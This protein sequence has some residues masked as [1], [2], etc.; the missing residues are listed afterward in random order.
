M[1]KIFSLVFLVLVIGSVLIGAPLKY[2]PQT[3]I[4]PDGSIVK[5]F[6]SGDEYYH[7][8][9]DKDG[10]TITF[11]PATRYWVYAERKGLELLPTNYIVG[12]DNPKNIGIQKWLM[13]DYSILKSRYESRLT[14]LNQMR[15]FKT[16]GNILSK[17]TINN[18]VVFVRFADQNEFPNSLTYY[19]DKFEGSSDTSVSFKNY[20]WSV[21]YNQLTINSTYYP[22]PN[23][24]V[25]VSY[26]DIH[27]RNYYSSKTIAPDSGYTDT[28]EGYTRLSALHKR[29]VEHIA[30]EVPSSLNIDADN[31]G[32]VDN[33]V[34]MMGG[35]P[36]GWD[37]VLWP[38]QGT[39]DF[40]VTI[41]GKKVG[42]YNMQFDDALTIS[43]LCHEM[44]HT[45]SAPDLYHYKP[46]NKYLKPVGTWDLMEEDGN[47]NMMAYMKYR[48]G[49][50]INVIPE[51]TANG[52]YTLNPLGGKDS[53]HICYKI[54]SPNSTKE[55]FMVEYRDKQL[56]FE[57]NIP[58]SGVI[59]YRI[60]TDLDGK[61]NDNGPPDE[62][63]IF[64]PDGSATV[65]GKINSAAFTPDSNRTAF[66][67]NTNPS[68]VLTNGS[69]GGI[70]ISNIK[71]NGATASFDVNLAPTAVENGNEIP[72][73]FSLSQNYPNP[74]NP[75]TVI[76]WQLA[77]SSHVTL[78]IYDML[79]REVA[80]LVNEYKIAG[81]YNSQFAISNYQLSSGVYFYTIKAGNYI[82][83][84]KMILMK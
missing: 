33:V 44:F 11:N 76:S 69:P 43:V 51:I 67:D 77:V 6:A 4:Q 40:N 27:T 24:D 81:T 80:T 5:C 1:K 46:E 63:H 38:I 15:L 12:K 16:N 45:L 57:K 71:I 18:L 62:V 59:V 20:F 32:N 72:A 66:N 19:T 50:W 17:G 64:R 84:K 25:V 14:R 65:N 39:A 55:Y 26:K 8:L 74:F 70:S 82:E 23:G 9:H 49:K 21:S 28:N 60:D 42:K 58:S 13:P 30:S 73:A 2:V 83:T 22:K 78:K 48:Y 68:C 54:K 3:L 10:F 75:S 29:A 47:Q 79:G 52:T 36:D 53:T 31:D 35:G 34:F 7:W 37:D 41:N 56:P 61:G